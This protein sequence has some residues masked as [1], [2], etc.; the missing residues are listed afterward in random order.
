MAGHPFVETASPAAGRSRGGDD[1]APGRSILSSASSPGR[2]TASPTR[3]AQ[4]GLALDRLGEPDGTESVPEI[5]LVNCTRQIELMTQKGD[6]SVE[7]M[8]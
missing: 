2:S 6:P 3:S 7:S 4:W 5:V 1:A 8:V